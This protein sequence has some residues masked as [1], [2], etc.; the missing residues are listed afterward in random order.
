MKWSKERMREY[1]WQFGFLEQENGIGTYFWLVD[2][3]SSPPRSDALSKWCGPKNKKR[4]KKGW[5]CLK[6]GL[7]ARNWTK[8]T[9]APLWYG[10]T[11]HT[12]WISSS[13]KQKFK[14]F[15][16]LFCTNLI[17]T[18]LFALVFAQLLKQAFKT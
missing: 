18:T 3:S 4:K 5:A 7:Q 10:C 13:L 17:K 6:I 12:N 9:Y 15:N 14:C 16:S 2:I 11:C 8:L 1:K